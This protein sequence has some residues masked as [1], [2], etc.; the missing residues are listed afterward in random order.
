MV[1]SM[2]S[3]MKAKKAKASCDQEPKSPLKNSWGLGCRL[4]SKGV[5]FAQP[6]DA[7]SKC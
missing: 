6:Y 7:T 1:A 3:F 5:P 2:Q 4:A